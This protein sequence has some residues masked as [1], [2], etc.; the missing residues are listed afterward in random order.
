MLTIND[1]GLYHPIMMPHQVEFLINFRVFWVELT[2]PAPLQFGYRFLKSPSPVAPV[3]WHTE[4]V[5]IQSS[6]RSYDL[7][8][9]NSPCLWVLC[10]YVILIA[11]SSSLLFLSSTSSSRL[12]TLLFASFVFS[13]R[14]QVLF[15]DAAAVYPESSPSDEI[16]N[17]ES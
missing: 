7:L 5:T 10:M 1:F 2:C 17:R 13:A 6:E 4:Q 12:L 9:K 15:S 11:L 14:A 16:D 8:G 3:P